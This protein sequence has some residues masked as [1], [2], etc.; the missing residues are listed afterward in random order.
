MPSN[1][2]VTRFANVQLSENIAALSAEQY[3]AFCIAANRESKSIVLVLPT[4]SGKTLAYLLPAVMPAAPNYR[5]GQFSLVIVPLVALATH[6][7]TKLQGQYGIQAVLLKSVTPYELQTRIMH[8]ERHLFIV[9]TPEAV[10]DSAFV[11]VEQCRNRLHRV[12]FDEVHT[13]FLDAD[14]RSKYPTAVCRLATLAPAVT[15]CS[16]TLMPADEAWLKQHLVLNRLVEEIRCTI[17]RPNLALSIIKGSAD[18]ESLLSQSGTSSIAAGNDIGRPALR[19]CENR[20]CELVIQELDEDLQQPPD[21]TSLPSCIVYCSSVDSA[22]H[23]YNQLQQL[24]PVY[25]IALIVGDMS[26]VQKEAI[27]RNF[28]A[29]MLRIVVATSCFGAGVSYPCVRHVVVCGITYNLYEL[30]Q[31]FGRA[32][33]DN[34]PAKCTFVYNAQALVAQKRLIQSA[35]GAGSSGRGG[36]SGGPSGAALSYNEKLYRLEQVERFCEDVLMHNAC[37]N[38]SLVNLFDRLPP[39]RTSLSP[40]PP[41]RCS[42]RALPEAAGYINCSSCSRNSLE[43]QRN[44]VRQETIRQDSGEI[45]GPNMSSDAFLNCLTH[46]QRS[47]TQL[48]QRVCFVCAIT[49]HNLSGSLFRTYQ[50]QEQHDL[51]LEKLPQEVLHNHRQSCLSKGCFWCGESKHIVHRCPFKNAL[52]IGACYTCGGIS[53]VFMQCQMPSIIPLIAYQIVF[54]APALRNKLQ[55][56]LQQTHSVC[57]LIPRDEA[58]DIERSKWLLSVYQQKFRNYML[59]AM[60]WWNVSKDD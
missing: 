4:G 18:D 15:L 37:I 7:L 28:T 54:K 43:R 20:A 9:T 12:I 51:L 6:L 47:V 5:K 16:A 29:G 52:G 59:V 33:R 40:S 19:P 14:F 58:T 49:K 21:L 36:N 11:V 60:W 46:L 10:D 24:R 17:W 3:R 53:H 56:H 27:T 1:A 44:Q 23:V 32:G 42:L 8:C 13:A 50:H 2:D 45:G 30:V 35:A 57:A 26:D 31:F 55:A 25:S 48:S 38:V 41:A 39:A 22:T 34:R